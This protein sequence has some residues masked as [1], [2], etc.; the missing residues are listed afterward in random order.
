MT[1][2]LYGLVLIGGKSTRMG[3]DKSLLK[4]HD[5]DQ[6]EQVYHLLD[7]YCSKVFLSCNQ[8]QAD[9]LNLP[10]IVDIK[11]DF[12]PLSGIMSAFT[13]RPDVAWLVVA[14]DMPKIDNEVIEQLISN[15]NPNMLATCYYTNFPEPLCSI[16]EPAAFEALKEFLEKQRPRPRI[17][18]E[19][20]KVEYIKADASLT[21]K[22]VN[23]NTPEEKKRIE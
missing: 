3:T 8:E 12:G 22:L 9:E 4:Y 19:I 13:Y 7:Q 16:W 14:C 11:R 18:L 10:Y 1:P 21:S 20:N 6:R 15:R 2:P 5:K 23:I 17:F